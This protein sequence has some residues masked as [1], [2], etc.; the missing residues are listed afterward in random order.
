V[1]DLVYNHGLHFE[2]V[3]GLLLLLLRMLNAECCGLS[4]SWQRSG[5]GPG[6]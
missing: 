5:A 1:L 4:A 3:S 6:V 2:H